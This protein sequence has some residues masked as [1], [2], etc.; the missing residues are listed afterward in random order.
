MNA[1]AH[2]AV[3][4]NAQ[5]ADQSSALRVRAGTNATITRAPGGGFSVSL[6][7]PR[8]WQHPWQTQLW[9][10]GDRK[11]WVATVRPGFV[12]GAAPVVRTSAAVAK[13]LAGRFYNGLITARSSAGDIERAAELA[14]EGTEGLAWDGNLDVKLYNNPP[15][16]L[17]FRSL[18]FDSGGGNGTAVPSFF[19]KLGVQESPPVDPNNLAAFLERTP[20]RGNRLLRAADIIVHQPRMALT[21]T[22]TLAPG[23]VTGISNVT[24][25][26]GLRS[27]APGDR[28][29]VR[30]TAQWDA[31]E[32]AGI[33]PLTGDYE[34]PAWDERLIATVYLVSPPDATMLSVPDG[35]W[36]PYVQHSLFWNLTYL[37]R[38]VLEVP[39][40]DNSVGKLLS[41]VRLLGGGAASFAV[42][43]ATA[44]LNDLTQN[45]LNLITGHS[46]AGTW[47]TATGGG[48][49]SEFP[50]EAAPVPTPAN[51]WDKAARLQAKRIAA[52]RALKAA[53]LDPPFPFRAVAFSPSLLNS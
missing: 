26:L 4:P 17:A 38:T 45:A 9:W 47:W 10:L 5:L 24:Q 39:Q 52:T 46:M 14:R 34:E 1:T 25:T 48:S 53:R 35:R 13:S 44:S 7:Q 33:D 21:S 41:A 11:Q 40:L 36:V 27:A 42:N 3:A 20:P 22:T 43:F 16:E 49:A 6:G 32:A 2:A 8:E 15:I 23:L 29:L 19:K 31:S 12:N 51:G 37:P 30:A 18:G 28:L 50:A